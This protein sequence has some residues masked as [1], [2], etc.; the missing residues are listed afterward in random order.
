MADRRYK[1]I[2]GEP[3]EAPVDG[4]SYVRKDGD[5]VL[6]GATSGVVTSVFGRAGAVVAAVGDYSAFYAPLSHTHVEADITDLKAYLTAEVNDLSAAVVW[7]NVPDANITA[8]SVTQHEAALT[9]LETQIT[10]GSL[11]ARVADAE[12]ISGVWTHS[13]NLL[14]DTAEFHIYNG[15][16][17]TKPLFRVIDNAGPGFTIQGYDTVGL[18]DIDVFEFNSTNYTMRGE[19]AWIPPSNTGV[20]SILQSSATHTG[21]I[22]RV[23]SYS[24]GN[25]EAF[26]VENDG[27]SVFTAPMERNEAVGTAAELNFQTSGVTRWAVRRVATTEDFAISR[28]NSSGV[29]Q[30]NTFAINDSTGNATFAAALIANDTLTVNDAATF[31][32]KISSL[33]SEGNIFFDMFSD[34]GAFNGIN[35]RIDVSGDFVIRPAPGGTADTTAEFG[36]DMTNLSWFCEDSFTF[37]NGARTD[38]AEFRHDGTDFNTNFTNTGNWN[39]NLGSGRFK[40][41]NGADFIS[42]EHSGS[43]GRIRTTDELHLGVGGTGLTDLRYAGVT[44]ARTQDY[45]AAGNVSGLSV[46]DANNVYRDVGFGEDTFTTQNATLASSQSAWLAL[47]HRTINHTDSTGYTYTTPPSTA[48]GITSGMWWQI[49]TVGTGTTTLAPGSG[50]TL[51]WVG[52]G[53][54]AT[55]TRTLAQWSFVKLYRRTATVWYLIDLGNGGVT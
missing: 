17:P 24:G 5:W 50:V 13:A 43:A 23:F 40:I 25:V 35:A 48:T 42:L 29:F 37:W 39:V 9:I 8:S 55:G 11:L 1:L 34:D 28:Y 32:H 26:V 12:T 4:N 3:Q 47:T 6:E 21:D 51:Y 30:E 33:R 22:F 15:L 7:A 44:Q 53:A 2:N 41:V 54:G 27:T 52:N 36:Y 45:S 16:G 14:I 38:N 31:N 46:R 20:T 49:N 10:D 18:A 19:F